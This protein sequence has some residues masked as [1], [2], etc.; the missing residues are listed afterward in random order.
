MGSFEKRGE[1]IGIHTFQF[2]ILTYG[3]FSVLYI[4]VLP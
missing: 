2:D 1:E 4:V 3:I